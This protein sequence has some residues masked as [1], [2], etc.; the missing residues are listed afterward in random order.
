[1]LSPELAARNRV[2]EAAALARAG[3]LGE[4]L[5]A[6]DAS[7]LL[8]PFFAPAHHNRGV[9]LAM[10]GRDREALASLDRAIRLDPADNAARRA[11]A[12]VAGRLRT[13]RIR[14]PSAI[15]N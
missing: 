7:I 13:R 15:S 4:A 1:M 2:N 12:A 10:M 8:D 6:I 3:R 14:G 5:S 11:R 9:V